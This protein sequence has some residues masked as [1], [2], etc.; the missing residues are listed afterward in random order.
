MAKLAHRHRALSAKQGSDLFLA[1]QIASPSLPRAACSF[2][3]A[4]WAICVCLGGGLPDWQA[5]LEPKL[6][7]VASILFLSTKLRA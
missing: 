3:D 6:V 5:G 7:V 4:V 2:Q 1:G